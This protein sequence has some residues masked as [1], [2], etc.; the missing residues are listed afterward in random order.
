ML[1]QYGWDR[2]RFWR[3]IIIYFTVLVMLLQPVMVRQLMAQ[4]HNKKHRLRLIK[5]HAR[6]IRTYIDPI[7]P[8]GLQQKIL[9]HK[10]LNSSRQ[11]LQRIKT[12]KDIE[13]LLKDI[14]SLQS[15][16]GTMHFKLQ[17]ELLE[18]RAKLIENGIS[19]KILA[20][21]DEFC[22]ATD[23]RYRKL[24]RLLSTVQK[25]QRDKDRLQ[26]S[27]Q[28]LAGL[29]QHKPKKKTMQDSYDRLKRHLPRHSATFGVQWPGRP[30]FFQWPWQI[31]AVG[32]VIGE[33][34]V[35][36]GQID[37]A[38]GPPN[39]NDLDINSPE[40]NFD[41]QDPNNPIVALADGLGYN[42]VKIFEYVRNELAYE[43][44]L[45]SIKGAKRTLEEKAGND[46]DL[47]S[48]LMALLRASDIPC[49]YVF[50][51]IE[52]SVEEASSW[53]GVTEPE[54]VVEL[55]QDNGIPLQVDYA[56]G[57]AKTIRI[58]HVWVKAYVDNF[59]YRGAV[60]EQDYDG[61]IDGDAWVE[62]DG[63]FKQH[64]FTGSADVAASVGIDPDTLLT[65]A[66]YGATVDS[67]GCYVFGIN[68]ELIGEQLLFLAEPIRDYL[69][70]RNL[71]AETV[72]CQRHVLEERYGILPV[73]DQYK[74]AARG[75]NFSLLP[76]GLRH[77][78]TVRLLNQDYTASF[79]WTKSLPELVGTKIT[80]LYEPA[81]A[82]DAEIVADP[83]I[84]NVNDPNFI[85]AWLVSL[86]PQLRVDGQVE[87]VTD[88]EVGAGL[89]QYIE[90]TFTAP[91]G[92]TETITHPIRAGGVHSLVLDP[93][94]V[95][96]GHLQQHY[97]AM[98]EIAGRFDA[99][100]PLT[101]DETIGD[102]LHGIGLSYFHQMDR[103]NQITAGSLG[104]S[105]TRQPSVVR[106]AW[107]LGI[108]DWLQDPNLPH[109]ATSDKVRITVGRDVHIPV[110]IDKPQDL[111]VPENQFLFTSA[112]TS[113][114]LEH[115][116]LMQ[117]LPGRQATSV[118]QVIKTANGKDDPNVPIYTIATLEDANSLTNDGGALANL[119]ECV[120]EDIRNATNGGCEI[121]IPDTAVQIDDVGDCS[122]VGYIKRDIETGA[123]DFVLYDVDSDQI[124]GA[125]LMDDSLTPAQ[126]LLT[127][128]PNSYP[129]RYNA[130]K[131][132]VTST[133]MW[134]K[135][136]EDA[137]T[138]A[139][140][141]Y[142][143]AI[144]DINRWF[145]S[146]RELDPVTTVASVLAV[147]GP[148]TRLTS[149]AGILNVTAGAGSNG[150]IIQSNWVGIDANEFIIYA[151]VTRNAQWQANIY[152]YGQTEPNKSMVGSE[153][154]LAAIFTFDD[155]CND[156]GYYRYVLTAGSGDTAAVPVEGTFYV[157]LTGSNAVITDANAPDPN[158]FGVLVINGTA[159]D[160][161]FTNY[162]VTVSQPGCEPAIY[163][164]TYPVNDGVLCRI[165][166]LD[167]DDTYDV[168][169]LLE[170]IDIAGNT[171]SFQ[172]DDV[173]ISNPDIT[174][175][176]V[177]LSAVWQGDDICLDIL[178][179]GTI[180]ITVTPVDPNE[181]I[182]RI[183]LW[184]EN[185]S[186]QQLVAAEYD[187]N[188][189]PLDVNSTNPWRYQLST[190]LFENG[191][192]SLIV[193][194]WDMFGNMDTD[195]VNF[196]SDSTISNFKAEP[197][198]V[199]PADPNVKISA[200]FK[201]IA[202]WELYIRKD[203]VEPNIWVD[204]D[205][206]IMV[207]RDI[208]VS[209]WEDGIY[210]AYLKVGGHEARTTFSVA[211]DP[212]V[213]QISNIE[214]EGDETEII[215][216]LRREPLDF[217]GALQII[218]EG[219][220]ELQ[221][222]AYHASSQHQVEYK[223]DLFKPQ[224]AEWKHYIDKWNVPEYDFIND[225]H[226][227]TITPGEPNEDGWSRIR[228]ENGPLGT[229]DFSTVENGPYQM[230]LTVR[231][232][233]N[234]AYTNVGFILD[235]PLK[236]GNIKFSQEDVTIPVGGVPLRV[237]RT[238]D[239]FKKDND[240]EF[241]YGWS[242]SIAD[243]DIE[244]DEDRQFL[245]ADTFYGGST[246]TYVRMGSNFARN[247]TLTLPDGQRAAFQF[248]LVPERDDFGVFNYY[249]AEYESPP[250]VTAKLKTKSKERINP[251]SGI[252]EN[253]GYLGTGW[254]WQDADSYDFTGYILEME[255]GTKY[256]LERYNYGDDF[257]EC[258]YNSGLPYYANPRG[259]LYLSHMTIPGGEKIDFNVYQ[260][261]SYDLP[262]RIGNIEH[263]DRE[264]N[265]TKEIRVEYDGN[266]HIV[267]IRAPSEQD[268][269]EPNTIE[270]KYDVEGNLTKVHKL[271]SK[272]PLE[273][274][275]TEYVYDNPN[276]HYITDINDPRG[277]TPIRYIYEQ[278]RLIKIIDAKGNT[279][280]INHDVSGKAE[281]IYDRFDRPTTYHYDERGRIV[282][283]TNTMGYTTTNEY[284]DPLYPDNPSATTDA[285]G[286]TTFYEYDR[287]GRT[288][289]VTDPEGNITTYRYDDNG[290]LR[291]TVQL[292]PNPENPGELIEIS[293][294][295]NVYNEA[296]RGRNLLEKTI[297]AA[298]NVTTYEYDSKNHIE[299]VAQQVTDPNTGQLAD[300]ITSYDYNDVNFPSSP[301]STTD[302]AGLT[303]YYAYDKNGNQ[304]KSWYH[305]EDTND[306][307]NSCDAYTYTCYDAAG[308]VIRTIRDV[309]NTNGN[310][311]AYHLT[312]SQTQYN[313]IGKPKLVT[314]EYGVI[315]EYEYDEVGSLV[316]TKTYDSNSAYEDGIISTISQTLYD[317]EDRPI[318]TI[319]PH[320][321]CDP[322]VNGTETF[323]DVLGRV[324]ETWRWAD[325]TISLENLYS[326]NPPYEKVGKKIPDGIEP[327]DAWIYGQLLSKTETIY[328][329]AGKV[330]E[331]I[332]YDENGQKQITKHEYD[333]AGKQTAVIDPLDNRTE[334]GYEGN[335]RAWVQD[336]RRHNT[337]FQYDALGR[338][339]HTIY[340][341]QTYTYVGY[342][343]LGR[344]I[345]QT[346]Q[347]GKTKWFEYNIA[348]RLAAAI[349]PDVND[350]NNDN[351]PTYPRYEYEYDIYGNLITVRDNVKEDPDTSQIDRTFARE[352]KFTYNELGNQTSRKLPEGQ[353]EYKQYDEFG[354]CIKAT[355]FEGQVTAFTYNDSSNPDLLEY[356]R[357]YDSNNS[358]ENNPNDPNVEIHIAYDQLGRKTAVDVN[359]EGEESVYAYQY[360]AEGRI[361]QI[362]S[363]Q[364]FVGYEYSAG[365]SRKKSVRTPDIDQGDNKFT[366]LSYTYDELG[367]L[368][369]VQVDKRNDI[370]PEPAE[371]TTYN[372]NK[373]GS[374]DTVQHANGNCTTYDYD[375]LNRLKKLT[376]WDRWWQDSG[377]VQ[378]RNYE[379]ALY[380]DGCRKSETVKEADV[381]IAQK[382][383]SYDKLNRLLTE[384]YTDDVNS[385]NSYTHTYICDLAGNRLVR[386]V[387]DGNDTVYH[388]N[389]N[390]QL[391]KE[392]TD[393][394][395][396]S[397]NYDLNGSLTQKSVAG[398]ETT[399]YT[400]NLQNRLSSVTVSSNPTISY[401]YNPDGIRVQKKVG[402]D[403]PIK[404]IIDPFNHTGY[405]QVF[406]ET[407]AGF[408]DIAYI[409]GGDILAQVSGSNYPEY[410]LYDGHGSVR[411]LANYDGTIAEN[412]HYEAYGQLL[413]HS[414]PPSTNL[415]YSGEWRDS[416]SG[417]DYLRS[418]WY[419]PSIGLFN[420]M[421]D[422][423]GNN[424]DP[425]SLHKYLYAYCDPINNIDPTGHF[426]LTEMVQ[427][428][429]IMGLVSSAYMGMETAIRGGSVKD[430]LN[431]QAN[432]F[433]KGFV[434][435]AVAYGAIWAIYSLWAFL[436]GGGV[437]TAKEAAQQGYD[438]HAKVARVWRDWG[439]NGD[440]HHF[441]QQTPENIGKFGEKAI[442]SIPNTIPVPHS[443][444]IKIIHS[445]TQSSP[446][447]V[448]LNPAKY[449]YVSHMYQYIQGLS[450]EMQY[451]W[452]VALYSY[453]VQNRTL[454][455]FDPA[456]QGLK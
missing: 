248:K 221:G 340:H 438:S 388:Y 234:K 133:A 324:K 254:G 451:R 397:Y 201:A 217:K 289:K 445:W 24:N 320:D 118:A 53:T 426:S 326:P 169:I 142:L 293:R 342:D 19:Q 419:D 141:S 242:Y 323:Y 172:R 336:A 439:A 81:D 280:E 42:P 279:I 344:R 360:D 236:L 163:N 136:A 37:S 237:I 333:K 208:D 127:C 442:H 266:D 100:E 296:Y 76:D 249:R 45:G 161:Y 381:Q 190:Y 174:P 70:G 383:W 290:N 446:A 158:I 151:D 181:N 155:H 26:D 52:L 391:Y 396:T 5:E 310:V 109:L 328:D 274:E 189:S 277:L 213:A 318:V 196:F 46:I 72:F 126:L 449:N 59:P 41:L 367:R 365:T 199:T 282:A 361:T 194:T 301:S 40:I 398:S 68:E 131:E 85:P 6:A 351:A 215:E 377:A 66:L 143:P 32:D 402:T 154:N 262:T 370:I 292:I 228:V 394:V 20:R 440:I 135:V 139:G 251:F 117:A 243:L 319:G 255:D 421:D 385:V 437:I 372:Y 354:R 162:Q 420:R 58:D 404:Y 16:L 150:Q 13:S 86:R 393:G 171:G 424:Y 124:A 452:G 353:I 371:I 91:D 8:V 346:N 356:Q 454:S 291:E 227:K 233:G 180:D 294:T 71:T 434:I 229:L 104:V 358:Y 226:V 183:E 128:D 182:K 456:R 235:C 357:F 263:Y 75:A 210:T 453:L 247:V 191:P 38:S 287:A 188:D 80:L 35:K 400:Y 113:S 311:T 55:F 121:T 79:V 159:D 218:N 334:Y 205:T 401:E 430:V 82:D 160:E 382:I 244:L 312:L 325:V 28:D 450:W 444:H 176:D 407:H 343:E 260:T 145:E 232:Q 69:A 212:P 177:N 447:T 239:S 314:N 322:N 22:R 308:R 412:Y 238:Y 106:V 288:T 84:A 179:D 376:H 167:F 11:A 116:V 130:L 327:E 2:G 3:K 107:D 231:Y 246:D 321:P 380:A 415:L 339:T 284:N 98:D 101:A 156:D 416:H 175:P 389:A 300:V 299:K 448:N 63:S 410:F 148:V 34:L 436:A 431:A 74:I 137:T 214:Y 443:W 122:Y 317:A 335:R 44:Y 123:S 395:T 223:I 307:C 425:P 329:R 78:F 9:C 253:Q 200:S 50:G 305:W 17:T 267:A 363:P 428:S 264:G 337:W 341:D 359:D 392:V 67:N 298:G 97:D 110:A 283:A 119:P 157:D 61:N 355:D 57:K 146:R 281:T 366:K 202:N 114:A 88:N 209:D 138:N 83:S 362:H 197:R 105:T 93:Q 295:T 23:K 168:N 89:I 77:Q 43:P 115:N 15:K 409:I 303:T 62:L 222:S 278:G 373:V 258:P 30:P 193:Y 170:V 103:F 164:S 338:Q 120:K 129:A 220:F 441:V 364:G 427:I 269:G 149:Q 330:I 429:A 386:Q 369:T 94:Q 390:D 195:S 261:R 152:K 204:D 259:P 125:L 297:D 399:I 27:L 192:S 423:T 348:G 166:T 433:L 414:D 96:G 302:P 422:Y 272:N 268:T 315:T 417:W 173:D 207:S 134:L 21:H 108:T 216:Q 387:T 230:L 56:G 345:S 99:N 411:Q 92:T 241:G 140:L 47:A 256:Y 12:G 39:P 374:L 29:L 455:G 7:L 306:P 379:Y 240:S 48:L 14:V 153:P 352:T 406:K 144:V 33:L 403:A 198:I 265:K 378:L 435:G 350:P 270:Y 304:I 112:L 65:N 18:M 25:N 211:L 111:F 368:K 316:E 219:L 413:A 313:S 165:S 349:L 206:S 186:G 408:D 64:T 178:V 36:M 331:T 257:F 432:W 1:G 275:V 31:A 250:G 60:R 375:E 90:M 245:N 95:T 147:T 10:Q 224:I 418:R 187:P 102:I 4:A 273:Y 203:A 286:N 132:L 332:A 184:V 276:S 285:L 309:N 271:I 49:R 252:W 185:E 87:A 347:A 384:Q 54:Q 405:A 51:T 225:Y 73:T